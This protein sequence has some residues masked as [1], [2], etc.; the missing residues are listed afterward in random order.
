MGTATYHVTDHIPE[1]RDLALALFRQ[2]GLRGL[3]N[4]EFKLDTRDGKLKLIECNAR[5][6]ASA[7]LLADCG[8]DLGR[9]VY[10]RVTGRP[11]APLGSY[12][13]GVH[14]LS[15]VD[16]VRAFLALRAR[17]ELTLRGWVRS[18]AHRPVLAFMDARDPAPSLAIHAGLVR[19]AVRRLFRRQARS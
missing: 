17:G 18:L 6:T 15:P 1:L 2:V 4:A 8:F 5:F 14:L 19:A 13:A 10:D 11:R 16:D 9:W 7:Q 3:A 12:P